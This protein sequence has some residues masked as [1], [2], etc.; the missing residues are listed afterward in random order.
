MTTVKIRRLTHPTVERITHWIAGVPGL[1]L[2]RRIAVSVEAESGVAWTAA[3][4]FDNAD[5][6]FFDA[7]FWSRAESVIIG[8]GDELVGLAV[9]D[10]RQ[11]MR[12]PLGHYF[13]SMKLA[14]DGAF[15]F[16]STAAD[17]ARI[18]SKLNVNWVARNIGVDGVI[19]EA[20]TANAI[21]LAVVRDPPSPPTPHVL[22]RPVNS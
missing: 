6:T 10:C 14:D 22:R 13:S 11:T 3:I 8:S 18:D 16:V 19:V 9:D 7:V 4:L 12:L 5:S 1:Q 20:V 15:L 17:L 21:H 2:D